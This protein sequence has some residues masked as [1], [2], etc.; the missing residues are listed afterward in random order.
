MHS[1]PS[2]RG[3]FFLA[4]SSPFAVACVQAQAPASAYGAAQV[5]A[6]RRADW[7]RNL[8]DKNIDAA[9]A[10][11][12]TDAEFLQ[13]DGSRIRGAAEIRKLYE[14]ITAT[15][16]SDLVFE[17]QRIEGSG[18]LIYDSGTFRESLIV[19]ATGKPQLSTGNYLTIYRRSSSGNWLIVEQAWTGSVQ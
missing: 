19:R 18:N 6:Q 17:S 15:Y 10:E 9:V 7:A 2:W 16:D 13:P 11:Y 14:T 3:L 1:M 4:L 8:H 5:I 12:A